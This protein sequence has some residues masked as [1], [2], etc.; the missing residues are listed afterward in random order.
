M[1]AQAGRAKPEF[2]IIIRIAEALKCAI[3]QKLFAR[4]F[5]HFSTPNSSV[6]IANSGLT[7]NSIEVDP[8]RLR[9]TLDRFEAIEGRAAAD[10]LS[11]GEA[12]R[13]L[14]GAGIAENDSGGH[15]DID[16]SQTVAGPWLSETLAALRKA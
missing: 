4:I 8:E 9:R 16:W 12:M 10:G 11:F 5:P 15:A 1:I 7:Q 2:V 14:A 6:G 13:M 3:K